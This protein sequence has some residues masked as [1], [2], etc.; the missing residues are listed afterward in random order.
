V[1]FEYFNIYDIAESAPTIDGIYI[2]GVPLE[3]FS[4]TTYKYSLN[5]ADYDTVP[6]ITATIG[7]PSFEGYTQQA[8]S[9]PGMAVIT[10]SGAIASTKY[11]IAFGEDFSPTTFLFGE[12]D[13]KWTILNEDPAGWSIEKGL[14]L[15]LPTQRYDING[16]TPADWKNLFVR[17]GHGEWEII[18]KFFFPVRPNA[19]YQQIGLLAFQDED[20]YVKIDCERGGSNIVVQAGAEINGTFSGTSAANVTPQNGQP[21]VIYF[22]LTKSGDSYL[23]AYSFDG[24]NYT[25][26]GNPIIAPLAGPQIGIMAT[27]N[28]TNAEIDAY[29][30]NIDWTYFGGVQQKDAV[31]MLEDAFNNVVTYVVDE[32]SGPLMEDLAVTVPYGYTVSLESS[33]QDAISNTGVVTRAAEDQ[34]ATLDVTISDGTRTATQQ[35][36]VTVTRYASQL[37]ANPVTRMSMRIGQAEKP[38]LAPSND[39]G[40][41]GY[42]FTSSNPSIVRVDQNGVVT[43]VRAGMA[44]I[45]VHLTDG[46]G[47]VNSIVVN[48]SR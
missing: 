32:V 11:Y 29:C 41:S 16:A 6:T 12:K 3:L 1:T 22:R 37:K 13:D 25:I 31:Q 42:I 20:N 7:N 30:E 44:V 26:V 19:T 5:A 39:V 43:A 27:R 46:S 10:V 18:G 36:D 23:G 33:N 2:D 34:Q 38:V 45:S 48:V 24:E 8:D 15:K 21:L 14:G 28:S 35:L 9:L 47:L 4:P 17:P 40:S